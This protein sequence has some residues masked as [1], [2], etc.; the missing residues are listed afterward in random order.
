[1][2]EQERDTRRY[3]AA[4]ISQH[5]AQIFVFAMQLVSHAMFRVLWAISSVMCVVRNVRCNCFLC[6]GQCVMQLVR[7]LWAT[8]LVMCVVMCVVRN[9]QCKLEQCNLCRVQCNLCRG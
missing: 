8:C 2:K 6:C 5:G 4:S 3:V 7:V 1:M 9:V